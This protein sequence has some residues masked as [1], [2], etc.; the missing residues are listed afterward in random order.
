MGNKFYYLAVFAIVCTVVLVASEEEPAKIT[1]G[2]HRELSGVELEQAIDNLH[3]TLYEMAAGDGPNFRASK[4]TKVTTQVVAGTLV[5][6]IAELTKENT[7]TIHQQCIIK[8]WSQPWL[9]EN[10]TNIQIT[11]EGDD[12]KLDRTW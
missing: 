4:V 10:A 1:P 6:Y 2:G 12:A 7:E 9:K 3:T 8:I 11:C 5:T